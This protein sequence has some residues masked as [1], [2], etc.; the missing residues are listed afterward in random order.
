MI[1]QE[2]L[3][4]TQLH[5]E[6]VNIWYSDQDAPYTIYAITVPVLDTTSPTPVDNTNVLN[7]VQQITIPLSTGNILTLSILSRVRLQSPSSVAYYYFT[8]LP[9]TV[10][11]FGNTAINV[12]Q[13]QFSPSFNIYDFNASPYNVLKG[14]LQGNRTSEY[15]MLADRYKVGTLANPTYTGPLNI[16]QLLSGSAPKA[17][18]QDSNYVNTGWVNGRYAGSKTT[19]Y[20]YGVEPAISGRFFQGSEVS[21]TATVSE[22][23]YLATSQQLT[24]KNMFYAGVG[25]TPGFQAQY[26]YYTVD[27]VTDITSNQSIII[28]TP[29]LVAGQTRKVPKAGELYR[30]EFSSE[31]FKVNAVGTI[32]G[33][34]NQYPLYVTRGYYGSIQPILPNS[35]LERITQ[36]Q[37]YNTDGNKLSGVP[38]GQVFVKE[39]G[40]LLKLDSLGFVVTSSNVPAY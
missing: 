25:D 36:V 32:V 35:A 19:N 10:Q 33:S 31:I 14:N 4:Y 24:F 6:K 23:G 38:K 20:T 12:D 3:A 27:S 39:T 22:V 34:T 7:G 16:D 28:I 8:I 37:V 40:A 11:E 21:E 13:L 9:V 29:D 18:V 1:Q 17:D 2:F 26:S 30:Q 5:P 15:I